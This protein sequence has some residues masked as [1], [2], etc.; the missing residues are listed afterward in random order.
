LQV[1]YRGRAQVDRQKVLRLHLHQYRSTSEEEEEGVRGHI[2]TPG[3]GIR[4]KTSS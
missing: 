4:K 3:G 1:R 2:Y